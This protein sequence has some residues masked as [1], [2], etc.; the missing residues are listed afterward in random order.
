[1]AAQDTTSISFTRSAA[2]PRAGRKRQ[3]AGLF[4]ASCG[5]CGY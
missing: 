3:D 1:V 2:R 5:G 4:P